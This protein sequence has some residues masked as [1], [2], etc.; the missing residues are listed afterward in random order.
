MEDVNYLEQRAAI[1]KSAEA[2]VRY[3]SWIIRRLEDYNREITPD[4]RALIAA[5]LRHLTGGR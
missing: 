1:R 5:E 4:V 3:I 2:Y